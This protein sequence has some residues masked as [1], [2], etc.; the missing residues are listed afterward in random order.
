V[1]TAT[2]FGPDGTGLHGVGAIKDGLATVGLSLLQHFDR[3]WI[4]TFLF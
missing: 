3:R 4:D 2:P 1:F